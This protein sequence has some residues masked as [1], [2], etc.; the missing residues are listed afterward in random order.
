MTNLGP[1]LPEWRP[2]E[3]EPAGSLLGVVQAK[4]GGCALPR[5]VNGDQLWLAPSALWLQSRS[6]ERAFVA[7]VND[8]HCAIVGSFSASDDTLASVLRHAVERRRY[9]ALTEHPG[10]FYVVVREWNTTHVFADVAGVLPVYFARHRSGVV[11]SSLA[12]PLAD[13]I[14]ANVDPQ[15]I[16]V[17]TM[18]PGLPELSEARSPFVGVDAVP[19]GHVL[20]IHRDLRSGVFASCV[21][22]WQPPNPTQA[23]LDVAPTLG[24]ELQAAVQA[25][26]AAGVVVSSDMSGGI[27]STTLAVLAASDATRRGSRTT[28]LTYGD[29]DDPANEDLPYALEVASA[30]P[31]ITHE[32]VDTRTLPSYFA[33]VDGF[34]F[35][36][37]PAQV[38]CALARL[39][40]IWRRCPSGVHLTGHGGDAIAGAGE[41]LHV[42]L[43]R[44]RRMNLFLRYAR[45]QARTQHRSTISIARDAVSATLASYRGWIGREARSVR[46]LPRSAEANGDYRYSAWGMPPMPVPWLTSYARDLVAER[47]RAHARHGRQYAPSPAQHGTVSEIRSI[48]RVCTVLSRIADGNGLRLAFPY[49]DRRVIDT[50]LAC[51]PEQREPLHG[52]KPLLVTSVRGLITSSFLDRRDK[53][54]SGYAGDYHHGVS[55]NWQEV[56]SLLD[57]SRLSAL[58]IL[59][60]PRLLATLQRFKAGDVPDALAPLYWTLGCEQ[61]LRGIERAQMRFWSAEP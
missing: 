46:N 50:A 17:R 26:T 40:A 33:A 35:V 20:R 1:P 2:E 47:L 42:D 56:R 5:P 57:D 31:D 11:Y 14:G 51:R 61:W 34:P 48:A 18:C 58:G 38:L 54:V 28:A 13:L 53:Y 23:L 39:R 37:E 60:P 10:S 9:D 25:R 49:F 16:A 6:L 12:R 41:G 32:L 8:T 27:D 22:Y 45:A 19:P 30:V 29:L 21:P 44:A 24:R 36:D 43:L 52:L 15:W 3:A 59:D 4:T 55:R 7:R